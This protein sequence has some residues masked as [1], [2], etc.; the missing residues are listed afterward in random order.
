MTD[1]PQTKFDSPWKDVLERYFE[2][3]ILFFFP[4]THRRI[5]WTRKVEF[6]DKELLSVV[7]DAE[8]GT[9][10]ADK[11]V[12]VYLL[13]GEENWILVHV[14]VQSQEEAEFALRMYTYNYRIYDKYQK[15]VV[16]LAILGDENPNWRPSQYNRQLF[17]CGISFRFPVV[18]LLDY[19]QRL[20]ELEQSRN[21][22]TTVVMA[23]LQAKATTSDRTERK[24]Q[25]LTLVKR[26]YELG[27]ER[28][29]IIILF[30][31]ID[32]MMTLP[33]DLAKEFWQEYSSFEESK[34]MQYVTSVERIGIEKGTRKGL[35][36]GIDTCLQLKFNT[37]HQELLEEISQIQDN[38]QLETILTALKTVNTV[39]ELR[40]IY[41]SEIE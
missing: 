31:F 9:R 5:D 6:L 14:E 20:S 17:G 33:A 26:L 27:F 23:H 4:Q 11:L 7:G 3:F 10:F 16:S 19:E 39:E 35:L 25:K 22:F 30:R 36:Q 37:M 28:D 40:K 8:I 18:K 38:E 41:R 15:F 32:W 13:N 21:P 1:N 12:K 29:S 24:Q 2:D 34:R